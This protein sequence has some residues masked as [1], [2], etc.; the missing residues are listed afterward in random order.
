MLESKHI[1]LRGGH[2][3]LLEGCFLKI[4]FENHICVMEKVAEIF[5]RRKSDYRITIKKAYS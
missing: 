5:E 1:E 3:V 2:P 4:S